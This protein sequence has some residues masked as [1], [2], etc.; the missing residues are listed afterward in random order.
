MFQQACFG[1]L[2]C[3]DLGV[4]VQ[5]RRSPYCRNGELENPADPSLITNLKRG[6]ELNPKGNCLGTRQLVDGKA[7]DYV[8]QTYEQVYERIL[9]F[10][11]GLLHVGQSTGSIVGIV[12]VNRAEWVI[13]DQACAVHKCAPPSTCASAPSLATSLTPAL[14]ILSPAACSRALCTTR[15][16]PRP[17]FTL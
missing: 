4:W 6:V 1:W 5:A 16:A 15:W 3:F 14:P 7:G 13:T 9:N 17:S 10:A 2:T 12:S 8:W 11:S